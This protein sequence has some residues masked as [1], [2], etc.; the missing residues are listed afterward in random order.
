MNL[1]M[2]ISQT[3]AAR[4]GD[5]RGFEVFSISSHAPTRRDAVAAVVLR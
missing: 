4:P 3:A 1:V 2:R 5:R